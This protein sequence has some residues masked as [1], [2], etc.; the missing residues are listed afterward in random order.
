MGL[1]GSSPFRLR[2]LRVCGFWLRLRGFR[3]VVFAGLSFLGF[4]GWGLGFG[5]KGFWTLRLSSRRS[6]QV[7]PQYLVEAA[8][9]PPL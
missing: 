5:V 2:S 7:F 3:A 4:R 1:R 8:A 9:A 6:R